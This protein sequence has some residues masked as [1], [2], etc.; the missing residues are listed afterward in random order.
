MIGSHDAGSL[1]M[2]NL[3]SGKRIWV[4]GEMETV[5]IALPP[6]GRKVVSGSDDGAVK[7]WDIDTCKFIAKWTGSGT[8]LLEARWSASGGWI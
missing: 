6:G 8:S 2:W 7:L 1:R 5:K 3:E 4:T